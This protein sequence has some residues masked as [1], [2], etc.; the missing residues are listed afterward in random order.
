MDHLCR[1]R[2]M[3][4]GWKRLLLAPGDR[5]LGRLFCN[6]AGKSNTPFPPRTPG[7]FLL[8]DLPGR[9]WG[10][11]IHCEG[12]SAIPLLP[13]TRITLEAAPLWGS[14]Y[15][16]TGYCW[17]GQVG[18]NDSLVGCFVNSSNAFHSAGDASIT[19]M[20]CFRPYLYPV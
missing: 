8:F 14:P 11:Q 12:G 18:D 13:G 5:C 17:A 4:T 20:G 19:D 6:Y 15:P 9:R 16:S 2:R 7:M 3:R 10:L 1:T